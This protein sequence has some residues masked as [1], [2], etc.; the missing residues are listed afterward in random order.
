MW[1]VSQQISG[2]RSLC[3]TQ[4]PPL[5]LYRLS[6]IFHRSFFYNRGMDGNIDA[7][8]R[9]RDIVDR[10]CQKPYIFG[11]NGDS[12]FGCFF[13]SRKMIGITGKSS[14][15]P[16]GLESLSE[17]EG[18]AQSRNHWVIPERCGGRGPFFNMGKKHPHWESP[19]LPKMYG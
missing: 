3:T 12:K 8:K 16:P 19:S 5:L 7:P 17:M 1:N 14:F 11:R 6:C 10:F 18:V 2:C 9:A 15:S 4:C 13:Y